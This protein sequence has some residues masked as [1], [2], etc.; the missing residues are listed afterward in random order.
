[1]QSQEL[2]PLPT[3]PLLPSLPSLR[4]LTRGLYDC[5]K[6]HSALG[7]LLPS[8]GSIA[9][10]LAGKDRLRLQDEKAFRH[11]QGSRARLHERRFGG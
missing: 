11:Y 7:V 4:R 3:L 9:K 1:M 2:T 10:A 6:T 8:I 5:P